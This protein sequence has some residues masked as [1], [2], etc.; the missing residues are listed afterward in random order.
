MVAIGGV[1]Q[2]PLFVDDAQRRFVGRDHDL[3]DLI[4]AVPDLGMQFDR[5]FDRGLRVELSWERDF[6]QHVLHHV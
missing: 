1:A 4:D 2:R 5:A 6:E 3:F